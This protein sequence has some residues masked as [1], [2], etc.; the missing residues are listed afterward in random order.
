[1]RWPRRLSVL[2]IHTV[3]KSGSLL[4]HLAKFGSN[5]NPARSASFA[6]PPAGRAPARLSR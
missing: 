2:T 5:P 4:L 6:R 1:M 3:E